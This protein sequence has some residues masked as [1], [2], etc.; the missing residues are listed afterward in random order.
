MVYSPLPSRDVVRIAGEGAYKL[1]NDTLTCRFE[2]LEPDVGQWFAL[3]SPQGKV[4]AEGLVTFAEGAYWFDVPAIASADFVRR[5]KLYRLRAKAEIDPM[6]G[7]MVGWEGSRKESVPIAYIDGRGLGFRA[8]IPRPAA[9]ETRWAETGDPVADLYLSGRTVA[10]IPE[11]GV[12]FAPNEV[13]AHDIGLDLRGGID[14]VKGCYIGQEVVSRMKHR[15]TARRR[16]AIVQGVDA[17][18]G[19]AITVDG[20]QVGTTG[21]V[22]LRQAVAIVRI[23]RVGTDGAAVVDGK[24][25]RLTLP[26]WANYSFGESARDSETGA[27]PSTA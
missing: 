8:I 7:L 14:F 24:P 15:G 6:P 11:L 4:L 5:M 9:I 16:P 26:S 20:R 21:L 13:F 18:A 27:A 3:L 23:D 2:G 12:D 19:S 22:S 17:P 25:V 1:L 10:G